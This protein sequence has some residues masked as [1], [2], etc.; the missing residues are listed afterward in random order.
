MHRLSER[1]SSI[2]TLHSNLSR[3]LSL[4]HQP[5]TSDILQPKIIPPTDN[6]N[7]RDATTLSQVMA[8]FST[9]LSFVGTHKIKGKP[10]DPVVFPKRQPHISLSSILATV[11]RSANITPS[12]TRSTA[13]TSS[14][15]RAV[16]LMPTTTTQYV[17]PFP[18]TSLA[19]HCYHPL[20]STDMSYLTGHQRR[21]R[22]S[23]SYPLH[24]S[25]QHPRRRWQ[26]RWSQAHQSQL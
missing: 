25:K 9:P 16:A 20:Q 19:G 10:P 8:S 12:Q 3:S 11:F 18:A 4:S 22:I 15:L 17:Y 21:R 23:P 26:S 14:Q 6:N 24:R 5:T 1:G 2:S 13:R 7:N